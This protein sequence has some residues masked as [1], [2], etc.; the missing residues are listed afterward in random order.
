MTDFKTT[1]EIIT[2]TFVDMDINLD[3][4]WLSRENHEKVVNDLQAEIDL[5]LEIEDKRNSLINKV[6]E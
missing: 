2:E 4:Q 3:K 6:R 1:K 5:L